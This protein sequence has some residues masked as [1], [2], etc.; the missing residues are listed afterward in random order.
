M[1]KQTLKQP[2]PKTQDALEWQYSS[3]LVFLL[4]GLCGAAVNL[5]ATYALILVFSWN[6]VPAFGMGTFLNQG[7][8]YFYYKVVH[9]NQE[10]RMRTPP[11]LH[12]SLFCGVSLGASGLL[13]LLS[14][15]SGLPLAV[16]LTMCIAVLAFSNSLFNRLATFSS[17]RL[18]EVEY[19]DLGDSF[20]DDQTDES[21]VS[22]FRAWY[23]RS[24]YERLNRLV[25]ERYQKGNRIADFGCG[26]CWWNR[27]GLPVLGVD[28]NGKMLKWAQ[29]NKRIA[30]A[31][32]CADLGH[33]GLP[34]QSLDLL[35][36]SE[37]LEHLTHLGATLAEARR[38]LKDK[39]V[40]LVTVPYDY[41]LGPFFILFNLNCLYRG[42]FRGS[43]YHKA[44][45]GHIH[46]FTKSRLKTT[47]QEN[48]F[49]PE[50]IFVV[51]GLL[52]YA[53]VRKE[54]GR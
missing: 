13:W 48:G 19:R 35:V 5:S 47:L 38:V 28:I 42:F 2:A 14:A 7:F 46:H 32:V 15:H 52:L 33:T 50:R 4:G 30:G 36:M 22:R 40:F 18:A 43:W 9:S 49:K 29:K 25:L 12:L 10:I 20:Y 16:N 17:A 23:H 34:S 53:V 51:N 26:N 31:K 27:G 37:V 6:P 24:R 39:G 11:L 1:K 41:F 45:C 3:F 21:K 44:R 8:H 54:K